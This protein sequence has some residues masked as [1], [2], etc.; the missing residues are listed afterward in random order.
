MCKIKY[1]NYLIHKP[2]YVKAV[3]MVLIY[4]SHINFQD[5]SF[6]LIYIIIIEMIIKKHVNISFFMI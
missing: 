3:Y 6:L 4:R 2:V 1:I 5:Y